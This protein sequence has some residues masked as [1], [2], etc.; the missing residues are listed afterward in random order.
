MTGP[1][2]A[3]RAHCKTERFPLLAQA[4]DSERGIGVAAWC[5]RVFHSVYARACAC[6]GACVCVRAPVR[7]C[8]C[9]RRCMR[10]RACAG[11]T[12]TSL[13]YIDR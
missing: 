2:R 13:V 8:A 1:G 4:T 5:A 7:A 12:R 3:R 10:V 11:A 6:A 9:V